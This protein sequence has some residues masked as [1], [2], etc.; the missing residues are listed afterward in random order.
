MPNSLP[1]RRLSRKVAAHVARLGSSPFEKYRPTI[2]ELRYN[3]PTSIARIRHLI[4]DHGRQK[5]RHELE[6]L[7][8]VF[9]FQDASVDLRNR[10]N[11]FHGVDY[12]NY[13]TGRL[14]HA[15]TGVIQKPSRG[16]KGQIEAFLQ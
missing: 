8:A 3:N 14:E 9:H 7:W 2:E 15:F 12:I 5:L 16:T 13:R 4:A 11:E 10:D 6:R 1:S